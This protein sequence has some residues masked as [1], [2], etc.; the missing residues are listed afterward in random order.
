MYTKEELLKKIDEAQ[1][2]GPIY[3]EY[4]VTIFKHSE[5]KVYFDSDL[6]SVI[7]DEKYICDPD[8][9]RELIKLDSNHIF[10]MK[11]ENLENPAFLTSCIMI[12]EQVS[13]KLTIKQLD[14]VINSI[15]KYPESFENFYYKHM[16]DKK[17]ELEDP[18]LLKKS[19]LDFLEN[20]KKIRL[21]IKNQQKKSVSKKTS[22][23]RVMGDSSRDKRQ[24]RPESPMYVTK[25]GAKTYGLTSPKDRRI[26]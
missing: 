18:E 14:L 7:R 3:T 22:P 26:R 8:I 15:E 5:R 16:A 4:L 2:K 13:S 9:I 23:V 21:D 19:T 10:W 17:V 1:R 6:E 25:S 11:K 12:N 24:S 20:L